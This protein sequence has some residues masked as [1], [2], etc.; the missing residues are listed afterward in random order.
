MRRRVH[1]FDGRANIPSSRHTL[2]ILG[3]SLGG[4]SDLAG[5]VLEA[6]M[7]AERRGLHIVLYARESA[8]LDPPVAQVCR[9]VYA[10]GAAIQE[11]VALRW[12]REALLA[13]SED[14]VVGA[15]AAAAGVPTPKSRTLV[16]RLYNQLNWKGRNGR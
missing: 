6:L 7:A 3:V 2:L 4:P 10:V 11:E 16:R 12:G 5:P 15:V 1:L 8:D 14:S 9:R 13:G